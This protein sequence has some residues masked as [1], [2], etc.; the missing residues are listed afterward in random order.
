M[1]SSRERLHN[2]ISKQTDHIQAS[3]IRC[4]EI[5]AHRFFFLGL[6][7]LIYQFW[8]RFF[9]TCFCIFNSRKWNLGGQHQPSYEPSHQHREPFSFPLFLLTKDASKCILT[10]NPMNRQSLLESVQKKNVQG[11]KTWYVFHPTPT[12][13][14]LWYPLQKIFWFCSKFD[15]KL[16]GTYT[17]L[18]QAVL[19]LAA[20]RTRSCPRSLSL[21]LL[22][23]N[24][25]M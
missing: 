17:S 19:S 2:C 24:S 16:L 25:K 12:K 3:I 18:V 15:H 5:D 7:S 10:C 9:S 20:G 14:A 8:W 1:K 11:S 6:L 21:T 4:H 13:D 23:K 22:N